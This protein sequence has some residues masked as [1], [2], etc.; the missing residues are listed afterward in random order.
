[1]D[2]VFCYLFWCAMT[3][4]NLSLSP[5]FSGLGLGFHNISTTGFIT[6]LNNV[7]HKTRKVRGDIKRF[8]VLSPRSY[9]GYNTFLYRQD[10]DIGIVY[11][12]W[13]G[14]NNTLFSY[15]QGDIDIYCHLVL[16]LKVRSNELKVIICDLIYWQS[17]LTRKYDL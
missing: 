12:W 17:Y 1:M 13:R 9:S 10:D 3:S 8:T 2:G 14:R 7:L 16:R 15:K 5:N 11:W 4:W 6:W